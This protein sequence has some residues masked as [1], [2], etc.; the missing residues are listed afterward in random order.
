MSGAVDPNLAAICLSNRSLCY[1][2][3]KEWE[4]VVLDTTEALSHEPGSIKT[5]LRRGNAFMQLEKY[6]DSYRDYKNASQ[7][8]HPPD[9]T[10]SQR[11][12][13]N[14]QKSKA[15]QPMR[16]VKKMLQADGIDVDTIELGEQPRF[17]AVSKVHTRSQQVVAVA[18]PG[19]VAAPRGRLIQGWELYALVR[20][21]SQWQ[22]PDP[23]ASFQLKIG[24]QQP[25]LV[26]DDRAEV[27]VTSKGA[28]LVAEWS[29][30][31]DAP[32]VKEPE[33]DDSVA[34]GREL[35]QRVLTLDECVSEFVAPEILGE[36]DA[37]NCPNCKVPRMVT[38]T[39][40]FQSLPPVLIIHL[41]RFYHSMTRR[42]KISS[43]IEFPLEGLQFPGSAA[44]YTLY[45]VINH[46]GSLSGGHYTAYARPSM[47]TEDRDDSWY[48]F[49]DSR[50][51]KIEA[52]KVVNP[53]AYLL[54]YRRVDDVE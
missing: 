39:M 13:F 23:E 36:E 2:Q 43:Q 33:V 52:S 32:A 28:S 20:A 15:L 10:D 6:K 7:L 19:L 4:Q 30:K 12:A 48:D 14:E 5:L 34:Q 11:A 45:G 35:D 49:N 26:T 29:S 27:D 25:V 1:T 46:F 51:T 41:K 22:H 24:M 18:D 40:G 42:G 54:F 37:W 38:K 50:V 21:A 31:E 47:P 9:V 53:A 17:A 8:R 16:E 3:Q 44:S